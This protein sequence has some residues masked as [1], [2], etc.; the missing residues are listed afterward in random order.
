MAD[1]GLAVLDGTHLRDADLRLPIADGTVTA[2]QL[3]QLCESKASALL[4]GLSLPEHV[5]SAVIRRLNGGDD[6][7]LLSKEF[8]GGDSQKALVKEY[9][10]A[11]ADE[12]KDDPLVI[13]ILDGHALRDLMDDE[14]DFAMLAENLF[15]DLDADDR[16]KLSK[17]EI[18]NALVHMGVGMGVPPFSECGDLLDNIVKT[19]GAE[20]EEQLGQAQ[21]AQLLQAVIQDI[22]DTLAKK[23]VIVI[24]KVKVVNG[25]KLGKILAD[26]KLFDRVSGKLFEDWK[27]KTAET[28]NKETL[29]AIL[30]SNGVE[31]GLPPSESSEAAALLYDQIFIEVGDD[32]FSGD[33]DRRGFQEAVKEIFK[34]FAGQLEVNPVFIDLES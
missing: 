2:D 7:G 13:S 10:L 4:F 25:S 21:F 33:L 34:L 28:G 32:K 11:L 8:S 16:G 22:A 15:T 27:A 24:R 30:V 14:D 29:R 5:K 23:N 18:K 26:E 31:L 19:H 6:V 3:I 20:G 17:N 1:G 12:L 9:F